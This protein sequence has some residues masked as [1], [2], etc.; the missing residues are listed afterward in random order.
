MGVFGCTIPDRRRCNV[1]RALQPT[2]EECASLTTLKAGLV[3]AIL[4]GK[5][6]GIVHLSAIPAT[7]ETAPGRI[8]RHRA[9]LPLAI[10]SLAKPLMPA[11]A[12]YVCISAIPQAR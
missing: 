12:G 2:A 8:T 4:S 1:R 11:G 9:P 6:S 3:V 10:Q 5:T 7:P